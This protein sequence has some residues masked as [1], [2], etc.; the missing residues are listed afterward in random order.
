[1]NTTERAELIGGEL[2]GAEVDVPAPP[3][4]VILVPYLPEAMDGPGCLLDPAGPGDPVHVPVPVTLMYIQD[5]EMREFHDRL[6]YR[7]R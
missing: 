5:Y 4:Q 3:P 6:V 7:R 1:M 2:D